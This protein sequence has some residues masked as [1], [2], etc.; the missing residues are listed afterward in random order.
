MNAWT[1]HGPAA[2]MKRRAPAIGR[3]CSTAAELWNGYSGDNDGRRFR[4]MTEEMWSEIRSIRADTGIAIGVAGDTLELREGVTRLLLQEAKG[5]SDKKTM[6]AECERIAVAAK[7]SRWDIAQLRKSLDGVTSPTSEH[8]QQRT[9]FDIA[10]AMD[11]HEARIRHALA[12]L[13]STASYVLLVDPFVIGAQTPDMAGES[14]RSRAERFALMMK[15]RIHHEGL[16]F[17]GARRIGNI[18]ISDMAKD[19]AHEGRLHYS[20]HIPQTV[21]AAMEGRGIEELVEG[22]PAAGMGITIKTVTADGEDV[23]I[24]T[25]AEDAAA[26]IPVET[27]I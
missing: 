13:R 2:K 19:G 23:T 3:I 16:P 6:R 25:T 9:A 7:R 5:I 27:C 26:L 21:R 17:E 8:Q 14:V 4:G 18:V 24:R 22:H 15:G 20:Q 12:S 10:D 1:A 11:R